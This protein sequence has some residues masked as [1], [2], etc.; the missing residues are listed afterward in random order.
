M[1][2]LEND[3]AVILWGA[4]SSKSPTSVR[5]LASLLRSR[6]AVKEEEAESD[7]IEFL[8]RLQAVGVVVEA[9]ETTRLTSD[10]LEGKN[11]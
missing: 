9:P 1:H 2:I 5:A 8:A 7:V 4:L 11:E 10:P 3:P 6:Y